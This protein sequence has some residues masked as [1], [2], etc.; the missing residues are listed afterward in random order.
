MVNVDL[1]QLFEAEG[2]RAAIDEGDVVDIEALFER[3]ELIKLLEHGIRAKSRFDAD[4]EPKSVFAIGEVGDVRDAADLLGID[5]VFNFLDDLLWANEVG[6]FCDD[7]AGLA[8]RDLLDADAAAA[9]RR[10]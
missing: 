10:L 4:D 9:R 1:K 3:S 5:A 8:G 7:E 2:A 6:Q